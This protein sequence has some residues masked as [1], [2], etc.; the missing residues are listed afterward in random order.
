MASRL[1]QEEIVSSKELAIVKTFL[2]DVTEIAKLNSVLRSFDRSNFNLHV[3]LRELKGFMGMPELGEQESLTK[4]MRSRAESS[5]TIT[6]TG[7]GSRPASLSS[8]L[9][10]K[11]HKSKSTTMGNISL[12]TRSMDKT[13]VGTADS[14]CNA[15]SMLKIP[16]NEAII[17]G[18]EQNGD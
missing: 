9:L 16:C 15:A 8:P 14:H 5:N 12:F 3:Y 2:M 10:K 17:G 13:E 7:S 18:R 6:G 1:A 11:Q 4:R